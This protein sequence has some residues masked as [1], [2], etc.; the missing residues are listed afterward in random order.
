MSKPDHSRRILAFGLALAIV[1]LIFSF[2]IARADT[3]D[4]RFS[5]GVLT[6]TPDVLAPTPLT[7]TPKPD[8][9]FPERWGVKLLLLIDGQVA[10][11][12]VYDEE[13]YSSSD[14]CKNAVIANLT[15]QVSAQ[16]AAKVAIETFGATAAVG[17]ACA[18]Q[19]D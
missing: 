7:P 9:L 18:M 14:A 10:R 15:L 1:G 3:F 12:I 16:A 6:P 5:S 19:L 13:I 4:E 8:E 11:S 17:I 2:G